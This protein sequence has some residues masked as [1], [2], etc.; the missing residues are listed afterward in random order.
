MHIQHCTALRYSLR[1]IFAAALLF[2]PCAMYS[3]TIAT[4][5]GPVTGATADGVTSYKG[6]PYAAP[7]IGPLRWRAPQPPT[8][9]TSP[10]AATSYG[11]DCM[12]LPFP[13]DAAPLGVAPAEDCL[14]MN[15]WL[16]TKHTGKKLPVMFWIYGGG[17]VNG[18]SS[19]SVY[20]GSQFAKNGVVLVSFNYRLG[21][22]GFF[23]HPA[24]TKENP[25]EAL[26]NYGYMDQIAALKWVQ[27][28]IAAFG[29]DP[30]NITIFGESAGG[31][32]VHMLMTTTLSTG[33]FERAIV[34]SG[35]GRTGLNSPHLHDT[36]PSGRPS[37]ESIG[38]A[39][40]HKNGIEGE[41][42]AAL[43]KLRA[44]PADTIVD[45][46][47]MA[48][49]NEAAATYS[50]PIIDGTI[51]RDEVGAMYAAGM[52]HPVPMIVGAN[53]M[54]I[55]FVA[56]KTKDELFASF[57]PNADAARKA[58][59]PDGNADT[60]AL[61]MAVGGDQFMIEPARFVARKITD[62]GQAA[63]L[64]R[65]S[66]VA[67]SMRKQWPGAPHAT[68]IPFVFDTVKAKYE[69]ALTPADEKAGRETNAYWVNFA[70][71]GDPNGPG[72]PKWPVYKISSDQLLNFT[73]EGPKGVADQ[74]KGRLD[75]VEQMHH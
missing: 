6:I 9:W 1:T 29:G 68:E 49:M 26:G 12:Q 14:Y 42:A 51:M 58:Y 13:S 30:K 39:F 16:P 5:S 28:N 34:E 55:G 40:A 63:Y 31:F 52:Q 17:W 20:D 69:G 37:A 35:G 44:L 10:L 3:Q 47:N 43:E 61:M 15:V 23:A 11:H 24:L 53:S 54:D 4:D 75:L 25:T 19:P 56:A 7:P 65:F 33:L 74:S 73:N 41:D 60:R 18:G 46:M 50:G 8:K 45:N 22:F 70:K 71:T 27:R 36:S 67:E 32:S 59:D 62:G 2:A 21:R 72:L 66:Y 57:G 48:S 38:L 64:Y